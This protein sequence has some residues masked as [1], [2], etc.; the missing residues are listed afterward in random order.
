MG[1]D[2]EVGPRAFVGA[3]VK[4]G[5][6][7][8]IG[9]GAIIEGVTTIGDDTII[10]PYATV[11]SDPQDLKY[12]G[13]TTELVIGSRN[14][15]R[16]YVNISRGTVGGGGKTVIGDDNLFMV[17]VHIGHDSVIGNGCIFANSVAVAGHVEIADFAVFGGLSAAHQFTKIG[18]YA[19]IAAGSK[20]TQDVPPFCMVHGDRAKP[21]GLNIIGLRRA[22]ITALE[23]IKIM[24]KRVFNDNLGIE[25]AIEAIEHEVDDEWYRREFIQ[26]LRASKRGLCR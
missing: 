15:I 23:S 12:A 22:G 6:R 20:V 25:A 26:F 17:Y 21:N 10:Y 18:Q 2:V 8:K 1:A 24:Y 16:E 13:E 14:K 11:G 19:M 7:V 9:V 3:G 4:L 5:N